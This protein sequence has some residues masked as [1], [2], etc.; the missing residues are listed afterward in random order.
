MRRLS[1][2]KRLLLDRAYRRSR[3]YRV[4]PVG[5]RPEAIP[6]YY[7]STVTIVRN[8]AKYIR[9]FVAFHQLVGV[10]HMLICMD[11]SFD[12]STHDAISDFIEQGFVELVVWP[13]FL[14]DRNNQFLAYQYALAL[15]RNRTSWLAMI[16]ADEFLFAPS[17][18]D[19]RAELRAR[20]RFCALSVYSH[21]FG[22]S[23]IRS[24]PEGGLVIETLIKRGA[25]DHVKNTTH[26]TI[27]RPWAVEAIRSA[28][29][30][31]LSD[32]DCLGWDEDGR[33]V[34]ETGEP[35]HSSQHLRINHYFTRAEEDF[36]AKL[37]RQYFG[38]GRHAVKMQGKLL[39]ASDGLLSAEQD[40]TLHRYLPELKKL[41][42]RGGRPAR[43][44]T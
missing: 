25:V 10:D 18:F 11:V 44:L 23:G 5:T 35:G 27:V 8:E 36:S 33:P 2:I 42:N 30:C 32:T 28:N 16:D 3:G 29:T 14:K 34:Y 40:T 38:K 7:L 13:R 20:E 21:T 1:Q 9:E 15:L 17:S 12:Q 22:T 31:V 6:E 43:R 39:E 37:S 41:M 26:R 24:I 19:L 4:P